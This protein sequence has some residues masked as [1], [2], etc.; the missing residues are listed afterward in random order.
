MTAERTVLI[1]DDSALMREIAMLA[2]ERAG[3]E[4]TSAQSGEAGVAA[5][6]AQ[7]PDA[8]LL[9]VEMPDM[10]GPATLAALRRQHA[11]SQIPVV[12]VTGHHD[13]ELLAGLVALGAAGTL[14]KPFSVARLPG[15]LSH[16][17]GWGG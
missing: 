17:L 9:D 1:V 13:P 5:A 11:T 15:E 12:F 4:V 2:L 6:A 7:R 10:D 8:V 14:A 16:L 3:W